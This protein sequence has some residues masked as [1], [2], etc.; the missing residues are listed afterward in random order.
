MII[1]IT[2]RVLSIKV[3]ILF[4]FNLFGFI[5]LVKQTNV[6][7]LYKLLNT[8]HFC[9][10]IRESLSLE[11]RVGTQM[12]CLEIHFYILQGKIG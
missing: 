1:N 6:L 5:C 7:L 2:G 8:N 10:I 9:L 11:C 3:T 12:V 4:L